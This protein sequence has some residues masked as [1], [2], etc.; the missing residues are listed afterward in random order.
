[1]YRDIHSNA[2]NGNLPWEYCFVTIQ[3]TKVNKRPETLTLGQQ[4]EEA[5]PNQMIA[6]IHPATSQLFG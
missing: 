3:E 4:G 1:M 2:M 5:A 6:E